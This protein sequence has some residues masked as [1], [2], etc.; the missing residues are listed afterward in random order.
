MNKGHHSFAIL[1]WLNNQRIKNAKA[2]IYLRL[3]V[4]Y[5]RVEIAT[6]QKTLPQNWD[7]KGQ[8]VKGR[9]EEAQ[10]I[11]RYLD[12]MQT[13]IH[14]HYGLLLAQE[15]PISAEIIKQS[16]LGIESKQKSLLEIFDLHNQRFLEKVQAGKKSQNTLKR[17][18]IT[19][20][21]LVSFLKHQYKVTDILVNNV[22]L[23]FAIDFEHYL[24]TVQRIG[25][26]TSMKYVQNIKQILQMAIDL[27]FLQ[28]NPLA[29]FKCSYQ[30]PNRD[31]LSMD[32]IMVLRDKDLISR[33]SSTRD[34]FC[35]V[36]LQVMLIWMY[37]T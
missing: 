13:D 36:V 5:K 33:L 37:I 17:H 11:N 14:K 23:S 4:N 21:K 30:H 6:H 24:S 25:S 35:F 22:K 8:R 26:N 10:V 34:I 20:H 1:L 2:P 29:A 3:T 9:L 7:Q 18:V 32:E 27:G 31:K 16:Y 12:I 15:K 19:R 28:T